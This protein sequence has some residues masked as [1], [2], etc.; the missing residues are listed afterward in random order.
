M[1]QTVTKPPTTHRMKIML[2]LL[3]VAGVL[4]LLFAPLETLLPI[5]IVVPRVALIIQPMILVLAGVALGCWAAPQLGLDAPVIRAIA[6]RRYLMPVV[7]PMLMPAT[8][9]GIAVAVIL[10]GYGVLTKD[11]FA[12]PE[13][14]DLARLTGFQP[15]L[16]SKLL[17]GGVAEELLSRWGVLSGLA[18][19]ATKVGLQR[20][21]ALWVGNVGAAL[22]FGIGHLPLLFAIMPDP[23]IWIIGAVIV[24]NVVPGLIFGWLF[25][26]RGLESVMLAHG[27]GHLIATLAGG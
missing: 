13:N 8:L 19:L 27:M 9:G 21:S 25:Q 1:D 16:I 20:A 26:N 24:G 23:P 17:Y 10:F 3:G 2:A 7:K 6:E 4:S 5:S 14:A 15:P 12:L 11:A 18:L 22:L